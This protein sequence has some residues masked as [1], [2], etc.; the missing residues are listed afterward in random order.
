ML[1]CICVCICI[2]TLN[3]GCVSVSVCTLVCTHMD[4]CVCVC[5]CV[6][7]GNLVSPNRCLYRDG[8]LLL[9]EQTDRAPA[10]VHVFLFNDLLLFTKKSGGLGLRPS[11]RYHDQLKLH[12]LIVEDSSG[13]DPSLSLVKRVG[14]RS[15]TVTL[16]FASRPD[17]DAWL[18]AIR[19]ALS[20]VQKSKVFSV[21]LQ[22]VMSVE[23]ERGRAIPSF[24]ETCIE[25]IVSRALDVEG[26][27]DEWIYFV[28]SLV[29]CR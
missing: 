13:G 28:W 23:S 15:E 27:C 17:K 16:S 19:H 4:A 9:H 20:D 22:Q 6:C 24:L 18:D 26:R 10:D 2:C 11:F 21:P 3:V 7:A 1:V 25:F 5:V 8:D 12:R 14:E 29:C